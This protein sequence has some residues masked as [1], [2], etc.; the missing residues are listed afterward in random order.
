MPFN[1]NRP[2]FEA[3]H[4]WPKL[5]NS[6]CRAAAASWSLA[7]FLL[8][9][10]KFRK[11]FFAMYTVGIGSKKVKPLWTAWLL[12]HDTERLPVLHYPSE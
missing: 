10:K 6:C 1:L 11:T 9:V 3:V 7:P 4:F 2:K 8:N 5:L 12:L